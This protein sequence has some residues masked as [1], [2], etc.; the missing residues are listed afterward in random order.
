MVMDMN[1]ANNTCIVCT[2]VCVGAR[3]SICV[4]SPTDTDERKR[5]VS[6]DQVKNTRTATSNS[7]TEVNH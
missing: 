4:R 1:G 7:R 5:D 6:D 2:R 3:A